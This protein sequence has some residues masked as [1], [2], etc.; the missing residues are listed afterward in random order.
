ML[1]DYGATVTAV[2]TADEALELLERER[3]RSS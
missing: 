3:P 2:A 1:E